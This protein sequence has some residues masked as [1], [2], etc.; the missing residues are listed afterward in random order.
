ML[1]Q[2]YCQQEREKRCT[3]TANT[4]ESS[5]NEKDES[6]VE[7]M[8]TGDGES[9]DQANGKKTPKSEPNA[10][11][12]PLSN[13]VEMSNITESVTVIKQEPEDE[14]TSEMDPLADDISEENTSTTENKEDSHPDIQTVKTEVQDIE[15]DESNKESNEEVPTESS[16]EPIKIEE[17][18]TDKDDPYSKDINIDPRTYCK[19]GHFHLLL[20]DFAKGK[21]QFDIIRSYRKFSSFL[22]YNN[23]DLSFS[24]VS[25]SEIFRFGKG[26]LERYG[27][28]VWSWNGVLSLQCVSMVSKLI[29]FFLRESIICFRSWR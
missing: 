8:E 20:E 28:S 19:L 21:E 7:K 29:V 26:A 25:I 11:P 23:V 6:N 15:D 24:N 17:S 27:L 16:D 18:E 10:S 5:S 3:I 4:A 2:A 13:D 12:T 9:T 14:V 1:I 22:N